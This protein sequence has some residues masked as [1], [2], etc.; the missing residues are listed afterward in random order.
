MFIVNGKSVNTH[1]EKITQTSIAAPRRQ[2]KLGLSPE[3]GHLPAF[4]IANYQ[5]DENNNLSPNK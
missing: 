1:N 2:V 3:G 4:V 5:I